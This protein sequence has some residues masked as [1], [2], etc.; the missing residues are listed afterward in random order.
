MWKWNFI[1]PRHYFGF[2]QNWPQT[3]R[4]K[5]NNPQGIQQVNPRRDVLQFTVTEGQQQLLSLPTKSYLPAAF[6]LSQF[7]QCLLALC[8]SKKTTLLMSSWYK[9]SPAV[10]WHWRSQWTQMTCSTWEEMPWW[11]RKAWIMRWFPFIT[12]NTS[13]SRAGKTDGHSVLVILD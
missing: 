8:P 4:N 11:W 10:T 2:L 5:S 1:F 7:A 3:D 6:H 9:S 13:N 12:C